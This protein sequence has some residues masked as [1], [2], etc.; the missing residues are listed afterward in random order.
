MNFIDFYTEQLAKGKTVED[1]A[2]KHSVKPT[3][4]KKQLKMG[5]KVEREHT[6]STKKAKSIAKDHLVEKPKYY[7]K[8]KKAG[9]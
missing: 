7:S 9:L 2:K 3:V 1:I 6:S 8:L 4:I 5:T